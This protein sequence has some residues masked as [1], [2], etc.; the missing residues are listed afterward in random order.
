M[1]KRPVSSSNTAG[2]AVDWLINQGVPFSKDTSTQTGYH[3]TREGGH[4]QRRIIHAADATGHVVQQTLEKIIRSRPNIHLYE[5]HFAVDLITSDKLYEDK[6][7]LECYGLYVLNE[8]EGVVHTFAARHTVLA[9]GGAGKVY[10]YTT[11]PDTSTGDGVAPCMACPVP[12]IE[13]GI[14][15]FHPTCLY[16]PY[17][18]SF[19][20]SE[21]V[22]GEGGLLK[23]PPDAGA[24][25][26]MRFMPEPMTESRTGPPRYRCP[27]HR[28]RN[29]KTR[30]G[31]CSSGH[32]PS[33]PAIFERTF[34]DDLCPMP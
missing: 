19:L 5:N 30:S 9:T 16:H 7:P 17:A 11:N 29:E 34:S 20:I 14:V 12:R 13:Y 4:S 15:Q 2:E 23:L 32:Q 1:K 18:K 26:G 22:R 27:L 28:L 6:Q 33:G 21:S 10:L 3:L 8:E 24:E 31:L 25:G